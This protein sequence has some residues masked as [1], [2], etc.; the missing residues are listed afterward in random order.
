M[1][2]VDAK[3]TLNVQRI[4]KNY[5]EILTFNYIIACNWSTLSINFDKS[6]FVDQISNRFQVDWSPSNVGF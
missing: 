4:I 3:I 2:K 5:I 6:S 1:S